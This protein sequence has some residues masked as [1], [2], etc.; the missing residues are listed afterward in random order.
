MSQVKIKWYEVLEEDRASCQVDHKGFVEETAVSWRTI[1][2]WD[3][4][5]IE[6]TLHGYPSQRVQTTF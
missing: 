6:P 2:T 4:R 3:S 5:Q 1:A